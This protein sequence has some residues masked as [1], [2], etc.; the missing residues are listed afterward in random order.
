MVVRI[1]Q[2]SGY[3]WGRVSLALGRLESLGLLNRD[4]EWHH[5]NRAHRFI[6]VV[7]DDP[8]TA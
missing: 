1:M 4:R 6:L 3:S 8:P 2:R 5:S 7:P